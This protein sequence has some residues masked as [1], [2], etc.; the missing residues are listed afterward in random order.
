[1]ADNTPLSSADEL[2]LALLAQMISDYDSIPARQF[3]E[4]YPFFC[5]D[6]EALMAP[7]PLTLNAATLVLFDRYTRDIL[8]RQDDAQGPQS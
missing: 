4:R 6:L 5:D 3:R 8:A 7:P 1:M 2:D